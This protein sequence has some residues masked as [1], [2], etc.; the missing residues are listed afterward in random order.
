MSSAYQI[1]G[2]PLN[3][4]REKMWPV[5]LSQFTTESQRE[6]DLKEIIPSEAEK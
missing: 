2:I 3:L 6:R 4:Q 5:F 1:S